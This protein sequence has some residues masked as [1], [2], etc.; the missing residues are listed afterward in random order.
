MCKYANFNTGICKISK[1]VCPYLYFCNKTQVYKESVVMP[2]NC[3]I[4]ENFNVPKNCYKVCL[5]R[6][7]NLY[8]DVKGNVIIIKNPFDYTPAY[9]QLSKLKGDKWKIKKPVG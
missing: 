6:R 3:K 2:N 4:A 5:E 8:I 9:V 7:G 1:D